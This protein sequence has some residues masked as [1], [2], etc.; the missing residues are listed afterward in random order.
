MAQ[1]IYQT[2]AARNSTPKSLISA[3]YPLKNPQRPR[4]RDMTVEASS[5]VQWLNVCVILRRRLKIGLNLKHQQLQGWEPT[6]RVRY[7]L[8]RK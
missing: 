6:K 8:K 7:V 3:Y 2:P 1:T 5:T 4:S